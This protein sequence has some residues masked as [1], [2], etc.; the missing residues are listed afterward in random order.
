[1]SRN[2]V[3]STAQKFL[4]VLD[5]S[6]VIKEKAPGSKSTSKSRSLSGRASLLATEPNTA[7]R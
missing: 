1:V 5:Q 4:K 2:R 3:N 7:I 6:D